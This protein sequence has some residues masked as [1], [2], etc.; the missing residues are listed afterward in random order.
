LP[1][2]SPGKTFRLV[3]IIL[4]FHSARPDS[5]AIYKRKVKDG[6]WIPFQYFSSACRDNYGVEEGYSPLAS[7]PPRAHCTSEYSDIVPL[8]GGTAVFS[9]LENQP[10][11][12][13]FEESDELQV[14]ISHFIKE[15]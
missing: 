7:G 9:T 11:K 3:Y 2:N 6:P 1:A 5:F 8:T 14:L 4:K 13:K 12:H 10:L 15:N